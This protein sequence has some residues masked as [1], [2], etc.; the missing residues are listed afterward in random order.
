MPTKHQPTRQSADLHLINSMYAKPWQ[1][2][3]HG[4]PETTMLHDKCT[5]QGQ[6]KLLVR[7]RESPSKSVAPDQGLSP[8]RAGGRC[9]EG[10]ALNFPFYSRDRFKT[11]SRT[12]LSPLMS[13]AGRPAEHCLHIHLANMIEP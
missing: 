11:R 8:T 10:G 1:Q 13:C 6:C 5:R 12:S 3:V 2:Y 4:S 7:R 9:E